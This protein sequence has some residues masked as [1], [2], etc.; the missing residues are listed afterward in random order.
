MA[1][2]QEE[3][4][5]AVR[6]IFD[7]QKLPGLLSLA[8]KV[9]RPDQV[10]V[11]MSRIQLD[12]S[13]EAEFL[14]Q[15]L[16]T[17]A[18]KDHIPAGL[19][20]AWGYI[21]ASYR[22]EGDKWIQ[23]VMSVNGI[24]WDSNRRTNLALGLPSDSH[25]WD[26]LAGWGKQ[27]EN[28][29]WL[30][31]SIY[32]LEKPQQDAERAIRQLLKANRPY[33]ALDVAGMCIHT[34]KD[35]GEESIP[36]STQ[37]ILETLQEPPK[38]DPREEWYS[39]PIDMV[40]HH[41]ERLLDVLETQRVSREILSSLEWIWMPALE[42]SERGLRSLQAALSTQPTLFVDVLKLV[43]RA[44]NE[45]SRDLSD[46]DKTRATQAYRLLERWRRIPGT[47]EYEPI[48]ERAEG[49]IVFTKGRVD[50]AELVKWVT[51]ARQ[52][53]QECGRLGVCDSRIG[54]VL[55]F[56]PEEP[57]GAWPCEAVRDLIEDIK[58]EELERGLRTSLYNRRGVHW[59]GKGGD[60]ERVLAGKFRRLNDL[61]QS[62]WPRT[63]MLLRNIAEGYE[64]E[65]KRQDEEDALEEFE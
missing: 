57:D 46:Q 29:Y 48:T 26:L 65:A 16:D 47:I 25:T 23:K 30:R 43:F 34:K 13:V 4:Y 62:R 7:A 58:S 54:H 1:R 41:V 28:D 64:H 39:P 61:I 17:L 10:G 31:T 6:D 44:E 12:E 15:T 52:L 63:G 36:I 2:V 53:A 55:A 60:Q 38:H 56:A 40:S 8:S 21:D 49:D 50:K 33:R 59:R 24:L 11:A 27:A 51:E 32:Y 19:R 3:R 14:A 5:K 37:L 45:E 20:T 42:H 9:E 18:G 35:D 22:R